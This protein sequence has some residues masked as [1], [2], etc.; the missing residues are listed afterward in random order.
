M[1][2]IEVKQGCRNDKLVRFGL[3]Y[4]DDLFETIDFMLPLVVYIIFLFYKRIYFLLQ[5][6]SEI[7]LPQK[8]SNDSVD[9][10]EWSF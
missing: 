7:R 5:R 2:I 1:S 6:S 9:S 10:F 4:V 3:Q 8:Q